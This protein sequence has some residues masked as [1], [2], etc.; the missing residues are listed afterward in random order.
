MS[1]IVNSQLPIDNP[2]PNDEH[3]GIQIETDNIYA[4]PDYQPVLPVK[5]ME[6]KRKQKK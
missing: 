3:P 4:V 6:V 2:F 5:S 1:P